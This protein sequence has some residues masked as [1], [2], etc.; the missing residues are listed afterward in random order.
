M[1]YR[2]ETAVA[3]ASRYLVATAFTMNPVAICNPTNLTDIESDWKTSAA[4]GYFP[5]PVFQYN[6]EELKRVALLGET[7]KHYWQKI[8]YN[9]ICE[10]EVDE[11]ILSIL[12]NRVDEAILTAEMA[13][14]IIDKDDRRTQKFLL[15]IYGKPSFSFIKRCYYSLEHPTVYQDQVH[16]RFDAKKKAE[17]EERKYNAEEIRSVF[18][19]VLDYYGFR[20][21]WDCVIDPLVK[22]IDARDK[23]ESGQ[24]QLIVPKKRVVDGYTL[25]K[26][27]G[28][29]I[30]SHIR[31]S[32]NSRALLSTF[33]G[34]TPLDPLI[35]LLAKADNEQFY[36]G[37]A[38]IS[39]VAICGNEEIPQP[40]Y[41]I[42]INLALFQQKSFGKVAENIYMLRYTGETSVKSAI[43][44]AWNTTRRI[45]RGATD[46]SKGFAFT[47]DYGYL[48]GYDV[49]KIIP[50]PLHDYSSL[51]LHELK[52]LEDAGVDLT[53][54]AYPK[55]D[56]LADVLGV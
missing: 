7:V 24:S 45:F 28:H 35:K 6:Q 40:F 32:E 19:A 52:L 22:T 46:T 42:A 54:P 39:D 27:I 4:A 37:V 38:K 18:T 25:A 23:T 34:D 56:A 13:T 51:T 47:K 43:T 29:E 31:G 5:D 16:P 26:L 8:H 3:D 14:G 12:K 15:S 50:S 44:S 21:D 1:I 11:A 2:S 10:D 30:E 49:A 17:L 9:C 33:I 36:E 41:T 53:S 55:K 20:P 48:A